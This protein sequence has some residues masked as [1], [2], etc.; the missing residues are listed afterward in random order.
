MTYAKSRSWP[1]RPASRALP[2]GPRQD[3]MAL[4]QHYAP[5]IATWPA[6]NRWQV[7]QLVVDTLLQVMRDCDDAAVRA[8]AFQVLVKMGVAQPC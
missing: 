8:N 3:V 6:H 2:P 4:V 7:R 1:P 5:L